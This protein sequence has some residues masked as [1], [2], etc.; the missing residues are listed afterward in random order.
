MKNDNDKYVR[1][2]ISEYNELTK[3]YPE[4]EDSEKI[5]QN[6]RFFAEDLIRLCN[7]TKEQYPD[8]DFQDIL[9]LT[10]NTAFEY[11]YMRGIKDRA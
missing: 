10:I 11:G 4:E 9:F 3:Q 1:E 7:I 2:L 5:H 8:S 6:P